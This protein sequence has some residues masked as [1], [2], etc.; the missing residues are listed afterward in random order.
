MYLVLAPRYKGDTL[1]KLR[2]EGSVV[3]VGR[4]LPGVGITNARDFEAHEVE[5]W[6]VG[7]LSPVP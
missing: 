7:T 1:A 5:H 6:A 4:I 3:A 2:G